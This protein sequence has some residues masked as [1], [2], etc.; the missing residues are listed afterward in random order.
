[1]TI[2][3]LRTYRDAQPFRPFIMHL[4]DGREIPVNHREFI[5][6]SPSGRTVLVFQPDDTLNVVDL[7]L[8]TDLEIRSHRNGSKKKRPA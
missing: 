6:P 5:M 2:E 4:A 7:L 8:V 1:M 3:Q